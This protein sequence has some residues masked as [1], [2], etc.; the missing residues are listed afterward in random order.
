MFD[1]P[2]NTMLAGYRVLDLIDGKG[3]FCLKTLAGIGQR[4]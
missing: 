3:A 4:N 1:K 2:D